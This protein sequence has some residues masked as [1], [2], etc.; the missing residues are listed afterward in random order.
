MKMLPALAAILFLA[1][2]GGETPPQ[3]TEPP[4]DEARDPGR[5]EGD[6]GD[7]SR[8]L[9]HDPGKTDAENDAA[10]WQRLRQAAQPTAVVKGGFFEW[11]VKRSD[12]EQV[13]IAIYARKTAR[14]RD[15][16]NYYKVSAKGKMRAGWPPPGEDCDPH[17]C[18]GEWPFDDGESAV[19]ECIVAGP[20][21]DRVETPFVY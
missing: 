5:W 15:G 4:P 17:D 12:C 20:S 8:A 21:G 3:E 1:A 19:L 11:N 9:G 10:T 13:G 16:I 14:G 6:Y 18:L 2:C 7:I